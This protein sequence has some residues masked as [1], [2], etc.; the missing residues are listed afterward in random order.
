MLFLSWNAKFVIARVKY[1]NFRKW[2]IW[3]PVWRSEIATVTAIFMANYERN[4]GNHH[5]NTT[6][7]SYN[8]LPALTWLRTTQS[9]GSVHN[10]LMKIIN[11]I[12][13]VVCSI[14]HKPN[15]M[16]IWHGLQQNFRF[17]KI[18][19]HFCQCHYLWSY[20][21]ENKAI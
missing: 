17:E 18:I 10:N 16:T 7:C 3:V 6:S 2:S 14:F 9:V 13:N 11:P 15:V 20:C 12:S 1:N 4:N 5:W 21:S 8:P 19:Y